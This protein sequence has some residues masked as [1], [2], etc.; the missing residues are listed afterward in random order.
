MNLHQEPGLRLS[1]NDEAVFVPRG[2]VSRRALTP[3]ETEVVMLVTEGYTNRQIA[4]HFG[5]SVA[6]VK[7][8]ISNIMI[9]WRCAN[10]AHIAAKAAVRIA[11]VQENLRATG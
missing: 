6:T 8:H 11:S 7:R 4:Q 10:R 2:G 3:R 9:K 5:L 1:D